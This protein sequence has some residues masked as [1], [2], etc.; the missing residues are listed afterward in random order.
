MGFFARLGATRGG[1]PGCFGYTG[2]HG[3]SS[4]PPAEVPRAHRQQR[5][6][7]LRVVVH[8][9]PRVTGGVQPGGQGRDRE[10][11]RVDVVE[12]A[13]GERGGHLGAG[14]GPDRPGT[15]HRLVRRVLVVVHEH[16][17]AAFLLPPRGRD[18]VG[19][20]PFQLPGDGHGGRPDLVGVPAR[21]AA[22][23]TRAGRGCR[24]SSGTRRCRASVE[25]PVAARARPRWMWV[26]STPGVG[27]RS[28]RSSSACPGSAARYGH[29]WKPRQP[30]L[31]AHS[32]W[33]MSAATSALRRGAVGRGHRRGLQPVRDVPGHPLLEERRAAGS[34]RE[35]LQQHRPAAHGPHQ[36]RRRPAGSAR[37][38]RP[39]SHPAP[40]TAPCPGG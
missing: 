19:P 35:P 20:A 24:S 12:L 37:R 30:R 33:S 13:P 6:E 9:Q 21:L 10:L 4:S 8:A 22:G 26:K 39:W 5:L 7:R 34:F 36:R 11:V 32:T 27:S 31:T 25:Q 28:I 29:T 18:Q 15:E 14:P 17:L 2:G 38:D 1:S 3:A 16:P 23:R 40:R